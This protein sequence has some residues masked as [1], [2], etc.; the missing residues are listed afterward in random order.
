MIQ[1]VQQ[2]Q[3]S[4]A[5]IIHVPEEYS[6]ELSNTIADNY[7]DIPADSVSL[8]ENTDLG[9][10]EESLVMVKQNEGIS[11]TRVVVQTTNN[12]DMLHNGGYR[13]RKYGQK[14]SDGNPNP[15]IYYKCTYPNCLTMK[16]VERSIDGQ[17]T[18]IIYK[19]THNHP[20][21]H[22]GARRNSSS[23]QNSSIKIGSDVDFEHSSL[24]RFRSAGADEKQP[25][26]KRWRN[27]GE[28][29]DIVPE[30]KTVREPRVAQTTSDIDILYDGGGYR[31]WKYGQKVTK[32]NPNPRSYY[33]CTHLGCP[34]K[35]HVERA[36]HD[37]KAVIT[38]YEG[39][40]NHDIPAAR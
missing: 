26:P 21:P 37:V 15:R 7:Y 9:L 27:K 33:K 28:N 12:I 11:E 8:L 35:K 14:I 29:E 1:R 40:H 39:K 20:K 25:D 17:V 3:D 34:V 38:T 6:E 32:G 16:K 2:D 5:V 30:N 19:G 13:W 31:W 10:Q 36:S 22:A 23:P 24:Q 18:E 4:T